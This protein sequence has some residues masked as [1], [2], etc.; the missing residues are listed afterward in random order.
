ML[1]NIENSFS[2]HDIYL[3]VHFSDFDISENTFFLIFFSS[4]LKYLPE[5]EIEKVAFVGD[6]HF[7]SVINM[8]PITKAEL[9]AFRQNELPSNIDKP[10][11][12]WKDMS[13]K[14]GLQK[15]VYEFFNP[16]N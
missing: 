3:E 10:L 14:R 2:P 16:Q 6:P 8:D 7:C 9:Q 13:E 5:E 4:L 15:T 1:I 12:F 11:K